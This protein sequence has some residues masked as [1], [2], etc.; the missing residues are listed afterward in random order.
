MLSENGLGIVLLSAVPRVLKNRLR[1]A[2][3]SGAQPAEA[4]EHFFFLMAC[5]KAKRK[6]RDN[7]NKKHIGW[8]RRAATFH[9][10]QHVPA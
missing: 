9:P 4:D 2:G 1:L 5:Q 10:C 8:I 7:D 6:Q 3:P